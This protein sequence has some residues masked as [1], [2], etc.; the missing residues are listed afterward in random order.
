MQ[1]PKC[2]FDNPEGI[3]FCGECGFKLELL[4]PQCDFANP[5]SFNFC[6]ECGHDLRKPVPKPAQDDSA[7]RAEV[8]A[9]QPE[10][11]TPK[12]EML[13]GERKHVTALFSD[14]SG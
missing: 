10:E 1:C 7:S 12:T 6:G 3:K 8:S 11:H 5:P 9:A 14:M 13:E 4:C 2:Q